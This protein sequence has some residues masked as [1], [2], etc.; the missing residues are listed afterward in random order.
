MRAT[1]VSANCRRNEAV[2]ARGGVRSIARDWRGAG[3]DRWRASRPCHEPF[4]PSSRARDESGDAMASPPALRHLSEVYS[5]GSCVRSVAS[6][7]CSL[8][9]VSV[10]SVVHLADDLVDLVQER[11]VLGPAL[12]I[13]TAR[14]SI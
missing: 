10:P 8:S 5:P 7:H 11:G 14:S 12:S 4:Q 3:A 1:Q 9:A 13:A 6:N 2:V